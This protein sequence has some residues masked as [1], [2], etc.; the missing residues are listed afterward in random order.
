MLYFTHALRSISQ[1]PARATQTVHEQGARSIL[2]EQRVRRDQPLCARLDRRG[3]RSAACAR[4]RSAAF[5]CLLSCLPCAEM[6]PKANVRC[7]CLPL[8]SSRTNGTPALVAKM[9]Q[10]R[11]AH[12]LSRAPHAHAHILSRPRRLERTHDLLHSTRACVY[13]LSTSARARTR[14]LP[15]SARACTHA[16]SSFTFSSPPH[17]NAQMLARPTHA[18]AHLLSRHIHGH[19]RMRGLICTIGW[20]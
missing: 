6:I 4:S 14:A 16:L 7:I 9:A 17:A 3:P 8:R 1:P 2:I 11:Q 12:M 20:P 18:H 10:D 19:A 13:D 15:P 5:S